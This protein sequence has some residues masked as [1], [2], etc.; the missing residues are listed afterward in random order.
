[1]PYLFLVRQEIRIL[2][3]YLA[4]VAKDRSGTVSAAVDYKRRAVE[5]PLERL[6]LSE[7]G[8]QIPAILVDKYL[9]ARYVTAQLT[10]NS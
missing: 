4:P 8:S 5:L 1:M 6:I 9:H 10:H 2:R 7:I 3:E